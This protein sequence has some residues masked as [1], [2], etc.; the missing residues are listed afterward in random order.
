MVQVIK[1]NCI[2][3]VC[4]LPLDFK[5][6][7]KSSLRLLQESKF[8]DFYNVIGQPAKD[9]PKDVEKAII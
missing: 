9:G 8:E 2:E 4:N 7:D 3:K 1:D 5:V 6:A